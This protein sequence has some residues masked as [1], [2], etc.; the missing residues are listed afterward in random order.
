[1][2]IETLYRYPVK[3]LSPERLARAELPAEGYFP[4]DRL[5][6]IENGPSGFDPAEP[7]HQPKIKYLMLMR[8]ESLARLRSRYDDPTGDLVIE[9][10]GQQ[11]LRAATGSESGRAEITRFFEGFMPDELRGAP[12]LLT[13]PPTYRFT[14]SRSGFV[15]IINLASVADL[16]A[17]LGRPLDPLRFRGNVMVSGLEPWEENDL[18]G[19]DL[20]GADGLRLHVLKRIDRCAATNVDPETGA[21]DMQI[22][23]ALMTHY[24]HVDCGVYCRIVTGGALRQGDE[25]SVENA[26]AELGI[27]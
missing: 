7:V 21:R 25:L 27:A 2:R 12:E 13:A 26:P 22:P 17:R 20:T 3:G 23:K 16:E 8:N 5:F 10:S 15:S 19:R 11:V 18:V 4:G 9:Q 24:G 6:A 1:M 14:D